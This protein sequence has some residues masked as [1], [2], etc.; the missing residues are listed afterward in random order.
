MP[1]YMN[2]LHIWLILKIFQLYFQYSSFL[3]KFFSKCHLLTLCTEL[4]LVVLALLHS[5]ESVRTRSIRKLTHHLCFPSSITQ[6]S[7]WAPAVTQPWYTCRKCDEADLEIASWKPLPLYGYWFQNRIL[8]FFPLFLL[9]IVK[10][11]TPLKTASPSCF[12]T[13]CYTTSVLEFL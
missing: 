6:W 7:G 11:Q 12:I 8:M 13:A 5:C 10:W 4:L 9:L 3:A 2:Y 1:S